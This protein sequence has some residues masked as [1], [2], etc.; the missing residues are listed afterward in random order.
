MPLLCALGPKR[1][2]TSAASA[3]TS[4]RYRSSRSLPA[5]NFERPRISPAGAALAEQVVVRADDGDGAVE[6][7]DEHRREIRPE[8]LDM[9]SA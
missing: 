3:A 9:P 7:V 4:K 6:V 5:S 2:T 8:V 1:S